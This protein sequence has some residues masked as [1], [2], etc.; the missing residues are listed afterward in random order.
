VA[1]RQN[2]CEPV[3]DLD[4]VGAAVGELWVEV[5]HKSLPGLEPGS[6]ER[7]RVQRL[8]GHAFEALG[9]LTGRHTPRELMDAVG[10][11]PWHRGGQEAAAETLF[12]ARHH[13]PPGT[14]VVAMSAVC[15]RCGAALPAPMVELGSI[16]PAAGELVRAYSV[17][18]PDHHCKG[19]AP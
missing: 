16:K 3:H 4:V 15:P 18:V 14:R 7:E 2:T 5:L 8:F 10:G 19:G 13:L 6:L 11:R 9:R 12:D 1:A 17:A